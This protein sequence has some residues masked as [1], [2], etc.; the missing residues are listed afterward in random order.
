[1]KKIFLYLFA[2]LFISA[3]LNHFVAPGFYEKM[4]VGFLPYPVA[5]NYL[6]GIAEILGGIGLMVPAFR[7]FSAWGLIILLIAV[8]PANINMAIH[9]ER[10][11]ILRAILYLRLPLQFL[12]IWWAYQYTK[13]P[14]TQISAS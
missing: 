1:M 11:D 14:E 10:W 2:V 9:S 8:F 6:S 4:L 3:G 13:E 7:K 12:L 5:L